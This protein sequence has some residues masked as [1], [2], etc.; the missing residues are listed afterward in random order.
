M[1]ELQARLVAETDARDLARD[2]G[3]SSTTAWIRQVTGAS[4]SAA[5]QLAGLAR[6][7]GSGVDGGGAAAAGAAGDAAASVV[8]LVRGR[9]ATCGLSAE[10]ARV[11]AEAVGRLSVSADPHV[12]VAAVTALLEQSGELTFEE[13]RQAANHLVQVVDPDAAERILAEQL[14][15]EEQRALVQAA[16]RFAR[17]GDGTTGVSGRLPDLHADMLKKVLEAFAAPRRLSAQDPRQR[18]TGESGLVS[19][20]VLNA[21]GDHSYSEIGPLPYTR[22]LGRALME[23]VEHLPTERLPHNGGLNASVVVTISHDVLEA[24]VGTAVLDT[25]GALSAGEVRRFACNA[26]LLPMV[27]GGDSKILDIGMGQR[28]FDRHQRVALAV[29][30]GGCVWR[31]CGRPPAWCEAHHLQPWSAGGASDLANGALLCGFHHRLAH[32]GEWQPRMAPDGVVEII[33]PERID[34][35]RTPMRHERFNSRRPKHTPPPPERHRS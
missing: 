25:G 10:R 19:S 15:G 13:W 6:T 14:A 12:L 21:D 18:Q 32:G 23:M 5:G 4:G 30:D 26:T 2:A 3:C 1:A 9:W 11:L 28:L 8:E 22:R 7:F 35:A 16:F 34:P 31:G 27:L 29:R 33:P 24:G 17:R 20:P